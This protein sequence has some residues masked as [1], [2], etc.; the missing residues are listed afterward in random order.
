ML[1]EMSKW[2]IDGEVMSQSDV[3]K[4][5]IFVGVT[6]RIEDFVSKWRIFVG[7]P[8]RI[9]DFVSKWRILGAE[10]KWSLCGSDVCVE[11]RGTH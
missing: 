11:V 2:R 7:V 4:W 6:C 9:E 8:C 3:S 1:D 5:R 10:K